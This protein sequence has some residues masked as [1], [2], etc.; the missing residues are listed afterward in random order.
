M[1]GSAGMIRHMLA[2]LLLISL[3]LP[4]PLT[5]PEVVLS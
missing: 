2:I 3:G 4:Q 1:N 5:F